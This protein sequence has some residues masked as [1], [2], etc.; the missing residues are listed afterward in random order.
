VKLSEARVTR[1]RAELLARRVQAE[2]V[3]LYK[4]PMSRLVYVLTF[5]KGGEDVV[6]LGQ[7]YDEAVAEAAQRRVVLQTRLEKIH[8]TWLS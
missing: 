5:A 7:E 4:M 6:R 3:Q 1:L 2:I 8:N